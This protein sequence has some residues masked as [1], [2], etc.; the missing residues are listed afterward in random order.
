MDLARVVVV[1]SSGCGKTTLARRLAARLDAPYTELDALFWLP[2]WVGR[3]DDELR[4]SVA[5]VAAGDRWVIDGNYE[6]IRDLVWPR[7]TAIVWLDYSFARVFSRVFRRTVR[8]AF[9]RETLFG[10]NRESWRMSFLS[11]ESILLWMITHY[12]SR[13]REYTD[14]ASSYPFRIFRRPRDT[15]RWLDGV[16]LES[17]DSVA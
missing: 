1:G 3:P 15:E 11:R 17:A 5:E 12:H 14:L 10:G 13:R 4:A 8:R 2:G 16:Q 9:T 7:A 6:R